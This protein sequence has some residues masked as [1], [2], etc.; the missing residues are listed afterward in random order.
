YVNDLQMLV[1]KDDDRL[2]GWESFRTKLGNRKWL[3]GVLTDTAA[4]RYLQ[5]NFSDQVEIRSYPGS[6]Q[7]MDHVRDRHID[8]TLTDLI[9]A[10]TYLD[11]YPAL[12]LVGETVGRG[13]FVVYVRPDDA[14]LRDELNAGIR[15]LLADGRLKGIYD[16]YRIWNDAQ[17]TLAS[18][19]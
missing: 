12:H 17:Q 15:E 19:E 2:R 6:T 14:R 9:A 4:E 16:K 1:R 13:Y 3:V 8:A 5:Q 7:A 11:R 18:P 10:N